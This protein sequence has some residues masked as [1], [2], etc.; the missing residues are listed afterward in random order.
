MRRPCAIAAIAFV[1]LCLSSVPP[2]RAASQ[3]DALVKTLAPPMTAVA[4][5]IGAERWNPRLDELLQRA[6]RAAALGARWSASTAAWQKARGALG[7]RVTRVIDAYRAS[8]ELPRALRAGL[9]RLFPGE[10]AAALARALD[11]PAGP[12]IIRWE[13]TSG[14][15]V[16]LMSGSPNGP[17][18]GTADWQKQY[19]ALS[20]TFKERVGEAVPRDDGSHQA[21]VLKF[22]DEPMGRQF[23]QL[24]TSVLGKAGVTLDGAVNLM[25]FDD[26]A[27]I[28]REIAEAIAT[29]K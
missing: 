3:D 10:Q 26:S 7:A 12:A 23:S 19:A 24:W 21:E 4:V 27:A 1:C 9:D 22:V 17:L 2:A 5:L 20:R 14:F 25:L 11:G 15:I 16:I 8:D 18:P 6:P 29:V 13:A 28:N